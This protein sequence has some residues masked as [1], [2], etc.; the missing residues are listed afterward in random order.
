MFFVHILSKSV[1]DFLIVALIFYTNPNK[2]RLENVEYCGIMWIDE[3][4]KTVSN[5]F[6]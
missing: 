1:Q 6:L 2:D 5:I 3:V 4:K